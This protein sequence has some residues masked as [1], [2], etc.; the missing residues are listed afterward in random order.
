[1]IEQLPVL[2]PSAS[3]MDRTRARCHNKMARQARRR[4]PLRFGVERA[5]VL[6]FG[7]IYLSS[8]AFDVMRVLFR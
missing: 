5:A 4:T 7:A 2:I 1:M 6:G 8:L 3:R